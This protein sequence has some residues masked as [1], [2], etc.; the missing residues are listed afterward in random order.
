[1]VTRYEDVWDYSTGS[2]EAWSKR[3]LS[4][5]KSHLTGI[6]MNMQGQ[7]TKIIQ[8]PAWKATH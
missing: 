3:K 6:Q 7:N 2:E 4:R 5:N 8:E 1:M